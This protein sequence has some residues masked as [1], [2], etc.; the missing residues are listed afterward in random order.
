MRVRARKAHVVEL[1]RRDVLETLARLYHQFQAD[2]RKDEGL[3]FVHPG[4]K[5]DLD[6]RCRGTTNWI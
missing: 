1:P 4:Q 5:G 3:V 6:E 2:I